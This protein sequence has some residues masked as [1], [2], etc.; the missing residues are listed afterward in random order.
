MRG[1]KLEKKMRYEMSI[2]PTLCMAWA[3]GIR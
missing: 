2:E 3:I 1:T